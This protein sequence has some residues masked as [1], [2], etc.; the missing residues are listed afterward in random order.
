MTS[1]IM[2]KHSISIMRIMTSTA[3]YI[4]STGLSLPWKLSLECL[5]LS[6]RLMGGQPEIARSLLESV[7]V[8]RSLELWEAGAVPGRGRATASFPRD[9]NPVALRS[10]ACHEDLQASSEHLVD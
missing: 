8:C 9:A 2:I 7:R 4:T 5:P 10:A 3:L 6:E 1:I